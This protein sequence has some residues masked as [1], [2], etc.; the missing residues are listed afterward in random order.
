M[1]NPRVAAES[2]FLVKVGCRI[3]RQVAGS[4][5]AIDGRWGRRVDPS[6]AATQLMAFGGE[7]MRSMIDPGASGSSALYALR[8]PQGICTDRMRP[9]WSPPVLTLSGDE[10]PQTA[11]GYGHVMLRDGNDVPEAEPRLP[12]APRHRSAKPP[13]PVRIRAAPLTESTCLKPT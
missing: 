6:P 9:L 1:F 2:R 7:G 11:N 5:D 8:R 10:L 13:S 3:R 12:R 4:H